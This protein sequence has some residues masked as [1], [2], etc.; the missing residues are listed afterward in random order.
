MR[1]TLIAL[2]ATIIVAAAGR[3]AQA[4]ISPIV[5]T[6]ISEFSGVTVDDP[7]SLTLQATGGAP[8]YTWWLDAGALPQGLTLTPQGVISGTPSIGGQAAQFT[9]KATDI[10]GLFGTKTFDVTVYPVPKP[11]PINLPYT[12]STVYMPKS[13]WPSFVWGG[14]RMNNE[15]NGVKQA[16]GQRMPLLG[17]Y[18]GD[19]P[20]VLDWQIKMAVDRGITNFVFDD[21][22]QDNFDRPV[23]ET[24]SKAF[25][26]SRY[27]GHMS[28]AMLYNQCST[29]KNIPDE[30]QACFMDKVLPFYVSQY[31]SQP[32]YLKIDG[33]PVIQFLSAG[34]ATGLSDPEAI[35][36]FL[37]Q[38][39]LYIAANSSFPGAYWIASDTIGATYNPGGPI[40]FHNVAS[41]GFDAVAPYYV[42]PYIWPDTDVWLNFPIDITCPP[43]APPTCNQAGNF[44]WRPAQAY[45]LSYSTLVAA[46]LDRHTKAFA[47]AAA[48]DTPLKFIASITTDFDSRAIYWAP[49]H[50][51]FNGHTDDDYWN[52]LVAVKGQID[53]HLDLVPVSSNTG[54]PLVGL[55]AWNEQS[56]SSSVEPGMS[57]FQWAD[58]DNQDPWFVATAA[59]IVFG[60][61]PSPSYARP[62]VPD[63]G[64][65]FPV[66]KI[67]WTFSTATGAGLDEWSTTATAGL[68]IGPHDFLEVTG[69][70]RVALNTPTYVDVTDAPF[71]KVKMLMRIEEGESRLD[72]VWLYTQNSDYSATAHQFGA[73]VEAGH[74]FYGPLI[75]SLP[76][77]PPNSEGFREY[78]FDLTGHSLWQGTVN[79]LE[80]RFEVTPDCSVWPPPPACS[81]TLPPLPHMRYSVKKVWLEP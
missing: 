9:V 57:E 48:E 41:A 70:G 60:G 68:A 81:P 53:S 63:L 66:N 1:Q 79:V 12:L 54:K 76:P 8:P 25:L 65:G 78:T 6:K 39:D 50:L 73:P 33:R 49:K 18:Q 38:A 51:Y 61:P 35:R 24:S 17:Y 45:G 20:V 21:Y 59:A 11:S 36:A 56:E 2:L 69:A 4:Q 23:L 42:L 16:R 34:L 46:S 43:P 31:F 44:A 29:P 52:M 13:S 74:Y 80:L 30:V 71:N 7:F 32:N 55:G 28:F 77:G 14:L 62:T 10:Y 3:P 67:D 19:N 64:R 26:A 22:W 5:T 15:R 75:P 27:R 58:S 47:A 37:H 72:K 40:N